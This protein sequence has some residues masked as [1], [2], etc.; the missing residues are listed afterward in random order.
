MF[1]AMV[2][3]WFAERITPQQLL[4]EG[5]A[6]SALIEASQRPGCAAEVSP[7]EKPDL[8]EQVQVREVS[9]VHSIAP[10]IAVLL[11]GSA[12]TKKSFTC[13]LTTDFM[14]RSPHAPA[15]IADGDAFMVEASC[16]G[17]R[18]GILTNDR[19][20]ATTDEVV[21]TF[22]TPWGDHQQAKA[23]VNHLPRSKC[24]TWT[25]GERDDVATA[26]GT[27]HLK[28]YTFQL[29]AFGQNEAC[30]WVWRP[31]ENGWQKRLSVAISPNKNPIDEDANAD[32]SMGVVQGLHDW[33]FKGPFAEP[34]YL[35]YDTYALNLFRTIRR[36]VD[37]WIEAK[38]AASDPVERFFLVKLG[39]AFTDLRRFSHFAMRSAQFLEAIVPAHRNLFDKT[40]KE[41]NPWEC[42]AGLHWWLRQLSLHAGFYRFWASHKSATAGAMRPNADMANL[43]A[44]AAPPSCT[45]AHTLE[46]KDAIKNAIMTNAKLTCTKATN[47]AAYRDWLLGKFRKVPNLASVIKEA[48]EELAD[49][50]LLRENSEKKRETRP[51]G[52]ILQKGDLG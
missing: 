11:H 13:D 8:S 14:T 52:S 35:C 23:H 30:E 4:E 47:T 19:V 6:S 50:G 48:A 41:V 3:E 12:S 22:P 31:S 2:Q 10:A 20:S 1:K 18:V 9:L 40:R 21:N 34:Q 43:L 37:D 26:N 15:S 51:Q 32:L 36:A 46:G 17:I 42:A 5:A 28:G 44:A 29:K 49:K 25:Q 27:I 38:A 24:N 39:F 33:M 7:R 16:K 45:N